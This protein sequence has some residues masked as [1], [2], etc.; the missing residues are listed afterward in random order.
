M[1][2]NQLKKLLTKGDVIVVE[3]VKDYYA[4]RQ[5]P[6]VNG[7]IMVMNPNTGQVLASVGGYDF[8][9]SKFDR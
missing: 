6:E 9:A 8:F 4:L 7:A 5:I 3:P 1:S 2:L